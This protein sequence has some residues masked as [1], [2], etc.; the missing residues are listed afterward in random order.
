M[1]P[2]AEPEAGGRPNVDCHGA[3]AMTM[4][5]DAEVSTVASAAKRAARELP[6]ETLPDLVAGLEAAKA[7]AYAR[8]IAP[9]PVPPC[10][11]ASDGADLTAEDLAALFNTPK[12][13]WYEQARKGAV[14]HVRLGHYV[15]F[16]RAAVERWLAEEPKTA[17]LGT[18]KK[19]R[20]NSSLREP[21]TALLPRRLAE[22][23]DQ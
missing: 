1:D 20:S 11:P 3:G 10:A 18:R 4:N 14:P 22:G 8:L 23:P 5:P 16:N 2:N 6:T 7:I 19:Q 15:R 13:F 21:A 9:A 17:C 12:S